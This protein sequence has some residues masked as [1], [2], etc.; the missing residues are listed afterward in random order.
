MIPLRPG[1]FA[2]LLLSALALLVLLAL[3]PGP[4]FAHK[5]VLEDRDAS[6]ASPINVPDPSVSWAFYG[7]LDTKD[8]VDYYYLDITEPLN[9]YTNIL[10]PVEDVYQS[11]R[12]SYAIIGP[13]LNA[14]D[15]GPFTVPVGSGSLAIDMPADCPQ[16][17]EPFGGINYWQ[18]PANYTMLRQPGR[19][20]LAVFD[21]EGL[22]GDYVLAVGE[23][24]S[25][26]LFDLPW[27]LWN[28][29]RIRLG[30]WDH[31]ALVRAGR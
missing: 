6:F 31:G 29:I 10:V 28:T 12:P 17:Y 14:S 30:F 25:F 19:Y 18:S 2:I 24:E 23:R 27:V 15:P 11:F 26:G 16:F 4:A 1:R 13:G 5:P 3:L 7:F 20:Y 21:R 8:N 9:L 22:R